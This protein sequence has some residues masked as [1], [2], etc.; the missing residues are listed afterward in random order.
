MPLNP[1]KESNF[2][3]ENAS[4]EEKEGES[5]DFEAKPNAQNLSSDVTTTDQE[6]LSKN[7]KPSGEASKRS[8]EPA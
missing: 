1:L 3:K 4:K 7:I 6:L 5:K 8:N 2:E